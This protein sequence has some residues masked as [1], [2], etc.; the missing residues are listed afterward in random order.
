[1]EVITLEDIGRFSC[2]FLDHVIAFIHINNSVRESLKIYRF[3]LVRIHDNLG[4][5]SLLW[6]IVF[7]S[8]GPLR[9]FVI[10][11]LSDV[12]AEKKKKGGGG[13]G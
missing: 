10:A 5:V 2:F 7:P 8:C 3:V 1:M 4:L 11:S 12:G 9:R 6:L 13:G